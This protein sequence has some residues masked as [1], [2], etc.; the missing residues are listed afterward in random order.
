[1]PKQTPLVLSWS[2]GKDS[3]LALYHLLNSKEYEVSALLTTVN[4]CYKRIVMHGVRES[5]LKAQATMLEIP[6]HTVYLSENPSNEEYEEKMATALRDFYKDGIKH[7]AFG[8]IFL[9]DLRVY[10]EKNI[11]AVN[12]QGVF[13]I[14]K[15][16]TDK[17]AREFIELG[18]RAKLS[19]V[20]GEQLDGE[21]AGVEYD[22][23]FIDSLPGNVDPCGENGEFHTFV[24]KG[25]V[26]R[27]PINIRT[28]EKVVR[29]NRFHYRDLLLEQ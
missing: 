16:P 5:L 12:M 22:S 11:N 7:V 3:S 2:G 8:D 21:H 29:D 28:G 27:E 1:M 15:R 14:W 19:C 20:D 23:L 4:D 9:E 10:R 6:L 13:P 18:F 26:F 25:P 24:Y 17:L